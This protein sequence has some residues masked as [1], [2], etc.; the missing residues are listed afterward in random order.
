MKQNDTV[1]LKLKTLKTLVSDSFLSHSHKTLST[2]KVCEKTDTCN[3]LK[4]ID[5]IIDK[6]K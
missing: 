6:F 5:I 1:F 2:I 4:N 3:N